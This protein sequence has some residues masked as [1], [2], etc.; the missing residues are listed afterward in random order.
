MRVLFHCPPPWASSGY[1]YQA[2]L[3]TQALR[4]QGHDVAVS[5]YAGVHDDM[6]E[7]NGIPILNCG[8]KEYGNG[9]IAYNYKRW[10]ADALI[11]LCDFFSIEPSQLAGLNV[12]PWM[13]IDCNPL[14]ELDQM[15]LAMATKAGA[16]IHPVAMSRFGQ[17]MLQDK[18]YEAAYI[19]HAVDTSVYS[20]GDGSAWRRQQK[21]PQDAFLISLVGVNGGR[22]ERK[23]FT[24]QMQ[25]FKIFSD[26]HKNAALYIHAIPQNNQGVN[27]LKAGLSLGLQG[28]LMFADEDTRMSDGHTTEYMAGMYRAS[29]LY[30]QCSMGEGFGVP[31][32]EAQ[33]CGVPVVATRCSAMT[34]LVPSDCGRLVSGDKYWMYLHNS[35][36]VEPSVQEMARAYEQMYQIM[37]GPQR[38]K[39]TDA[40]ERNASKYDIKKIGPMWNE[41]LTK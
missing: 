39:Y 23:S 3:F 37:T 10:N 19:P 18:G 33:A 7:W 31:I 17:Q 8:G 30:T 25:A 34:E 35:W 24:R 41:V 28:R 27:L 36:W 21:L 29:N 38:K 14:S 40:A 22:P 1:G 5:A 15:S 11:L 16:Q 13:P 20:P 4:D 12:Y 32:I 2:N 26:K 6:R 9:S